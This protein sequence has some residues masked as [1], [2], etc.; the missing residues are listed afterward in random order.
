M[1]IDFG[2]ALR[3]PSLWLTAWALVTVPA[4]LAVWPAAHY[5]VVD[6]LSLS[7]WNYFGW[8]MYTVPGPRGSVRVKAVSP[9]EAYV[10]ME[11]T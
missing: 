3:H 11:W 7:P 10:L 2:T 9:T 8:A 1:T 4:M 5:F 6:A